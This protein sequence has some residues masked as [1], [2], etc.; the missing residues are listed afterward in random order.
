V[1]LS[2]TSTLPEVAVA[3]GAQ[4]RRRGITAV[5]TGG[6][7]VSVYTDGS[8]V[9]KDAD[10]VIQGKVRQDALDDALAELGYLRTGDRYVHATVEFY[11]EF[12]PG[13]LAI[14]ADL[15]IRPAEVTIAGD[16]ALAL[17]PT[18]S[19]RDRLAAFFHWRDRQSLQ[20]AVAVARHQTVD[21]EAIRTWSRSEG[22]LDDYH[23]FLR[24]LRR[25]G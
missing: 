17:S 21:L 25:V 16:I 6:A 4:L 7:C 10:F 18:D 20:L 15:A 3:V 1:K 14:G 24:D 12:P 8:Y 19:C 13:P 11:V 9:S 22:K 23:E 2:A 5:L